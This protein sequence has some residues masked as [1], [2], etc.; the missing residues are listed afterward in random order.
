MLVDILMI[1][2][3]LMF[4]LLGMPSLLFM[5]ASFGD[6]SDSDDPINRA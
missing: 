6:S 5:L 3:G 4:V 1:A 2:S